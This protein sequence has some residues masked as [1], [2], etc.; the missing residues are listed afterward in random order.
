MFEIPEFPEPPPAGSEGLPP[1]ATMPS[2]QSRYE[3][4]SAAYLLSNDFVTTLFCP[5]STKARN[6]A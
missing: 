4:R 2:K 5:Y 1:H 3:L 6:S